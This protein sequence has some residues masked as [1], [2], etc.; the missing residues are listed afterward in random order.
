MIGDV[1]R[2]ELALFFCLKSFKLSE[3]NPHCCGR[4]QCQP[5]GFTVHM[6]SDMIF[7]VNFCDVE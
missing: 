6:N 4:E 3:E 5:E 2:L 1:L 7:G